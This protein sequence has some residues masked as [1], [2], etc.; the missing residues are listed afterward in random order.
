MYGNSTLG[1]A[2]FPPVGKNF[3]VRSIW[4]EAIIS[5]SDSF[6]DWPE[7][8]GRLPMK[9]CVC[10]GFPCQIWPDDMGR[11]GYKGGKVNQVGSSVWGRS[12][13]CARGVNG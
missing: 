11:A 13:I 5:I 6:Q 1:R 12:A 7:A 10:E 3:I 4:I 2:S 9:N 8:Y